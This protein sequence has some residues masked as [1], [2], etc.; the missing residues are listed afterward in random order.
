MT[1]TTMTAIQQNESPSTIEQR[2]PSC[3]TCIDSKE[4]VSCLPPDLV[5]NDPRRPLKHTD[6]NGSA[7]HYALK[8]LWYSVIFILLIEMLERFACY[9]INNSQTA[10]LTGE[11]NTHWNA[12]MTATRA[13]TF[14]SATQGIGK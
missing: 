13:T 3:T 12:N 14:G 5:S 9:G 11:Y 6:R 1:T 4:Q 7:C 2:I 8:P 10:Y